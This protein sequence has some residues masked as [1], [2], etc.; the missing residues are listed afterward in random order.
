MSAISDRDTVAAA[1][2]VASISL[3]H[4]LSGFGRVLVTL[5]TRRLFYFASF[6]HTIITAF[7]LLTWAIYLIVR[8]IISVLTDEKRFASYLDVTGI[9]PSI[10]LGANDLQTKRKLYRW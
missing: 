3:N 2:S 9:Q 8:A 1:L 10:P 6:I 7:F 5:Q 4:L